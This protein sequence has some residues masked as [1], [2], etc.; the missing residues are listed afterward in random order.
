MCVWNGVISLLSLARF[1]LVCG[2]VHSKHHR[3]L[4]HIRKETEREKKRRRNVAAAV[5]G[6]SSEPVRATQYLSLHYSC[7]MCSPSSQPQSPEDWVD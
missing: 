7:D 2:M 1:E 6:D 5:T 3:L 4:T